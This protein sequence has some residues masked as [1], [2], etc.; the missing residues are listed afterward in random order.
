[1]ENKAFLYQNFDTAR[2]TFISSISYWSRLIREEM[3]QYSLDLNDNHIDF[4][5]EMI[6]ENL[7]PR[8]LDFK[9]MFDKYKYKK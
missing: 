4:V 7:I 8:I 1:M 9:K 5:Y 3:V 2:K 6:I